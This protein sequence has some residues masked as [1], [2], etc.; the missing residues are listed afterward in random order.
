VTLFEDIGGVEWLDWHI[1]A[2][3]VLLCA[4]LLAAYFYTIN[5]LRPRLSDAGRVR[6]TQ[7]VL[8]CLGVLAIYV[9]TGTPIHDLSEQ[10]L[11]SMHMVQHLMLTL[12]APPLLIAGMP[13]WLWQAMLSGRWVL[14]VARV[15]LHPLV[16]F[17]VFNFLIVITHLPFVMD[18][19]LREHWFHFV[20]HAGLV[21]SAMMM[22]WPV[23]G[24][25][26][27]LPRLTY[28]YQMAYLFVQSI[29]PAVIA[30]FITF[31]ETAV[32]DFYEAAPRIWHISAVEDQ[33]MAGGIMKMTGTLILWSFIGVAFFRWYAKEEAEAQGPAWSEVEEEL[34][35]LGL[36][37]R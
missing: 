7:V 1:H 20:V 18:Y 36:E 29:L 16:A 35:E 12:V 21:G 22:W 27:E 4:T 37:K 23:V 15:L 10:Y 11:L 9:A 32:Y 5:V 24:G 3:V 34:R 19:A 2:D 6:N 28:P 8:Y 13:G 31:S 26:P 33:Q 25:I 17:G 30:S 14:P